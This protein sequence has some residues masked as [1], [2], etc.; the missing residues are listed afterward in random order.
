MK[1]IDRSRRNIHAKITCRKG[2]EVL[3]IRKGIGWN[4]KESTEPLELFFSLLPNTITGKSTSVEEE[5]SEKYISFSR[6]IAQQHEVHSSSLVSKM[7]VSDSVQHS[8]PSSEC[9]SDEEISPT[10]NA[11]NSIRKKVICRAIDLI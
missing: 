10:L 11:K 7:F 5:T 2:N 1:Q 8:Q 9:F 6:C 4:F 3:V